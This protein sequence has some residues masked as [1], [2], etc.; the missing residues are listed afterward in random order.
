MKSPPAAVKLVMEA[1]CQMLGVK[2]KRINDPA[3]PSKKLNDFWGPSQVEGGGR[4]GGGR[5]GTLG[6]QRPPAEDIAGECVP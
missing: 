2:S 4:G 5:R 1:V 6:N 3:D